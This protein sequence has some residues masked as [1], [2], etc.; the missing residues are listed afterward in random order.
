V[1]YLESI[2]AEVLSPKTPQERADY[3]ELVMANS[4]GTLAGA[5]TSHELFGTQKKKLE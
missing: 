1:T 4:L 5:R 2:P 3:V